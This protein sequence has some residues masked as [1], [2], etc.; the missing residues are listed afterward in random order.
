MIVHRFMSA[1][2]YDKLLRGETLVNYSNHQGCRTLSR[3][4]C[5]FT[6]NPEEAIHWLSGCCDCDYCITMD[7]PSELLARSVGVYSNPKGGTIIRTEYCLTSYD[8][9]TVKIL[10][11]DAQFHQL[12]EQCRALRR[13][14][15]LPPI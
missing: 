11:A 13:I 1:T 9:N 14:G 3:G 12:A 10:K 15:L 6:E 2:E 4:F 8:R 7:I 5:F